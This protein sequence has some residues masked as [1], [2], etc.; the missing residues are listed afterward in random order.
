MNK[1][2]VITLGVHKSYR[3]YFG[4]RSLTAPRMKR[5][6]KKYNLDFHIIENKVYDHP[7]Y[8][9]LQLKNYIK[10]YDRI[11]YLDMDVIIRNDA[12][13][14]FDIV[15]R[16]LLGIFNE[17]PL[18]ICN[19]GQETIDLY[20]KYTQ[21]HIKWNGEYY[22]TGVMLFNKQNICVLDDDLPCLE[23]LYADQGYIN[24]QIQ[25]KKVKCFDIGFAFNG[26]NNGVIHGKDR[27]MKAYFIH[28]NG[29]GTFENKSEFLK[30][31]IERVEE[32]EKELGI[33]DK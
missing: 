30:Q 17:E 32:I 25:Y 6:C 27:L 33:G 11:L 19:C 4:M 20:Y 15:P 26:L 31:E 29:C 1:N 9:K 18:K 16:D 2:C 21:Q 3:S 14:L 22:N 28:M 23:Q 12:P 24:Y 13:N 7:A 5:Y 8:N 10:D